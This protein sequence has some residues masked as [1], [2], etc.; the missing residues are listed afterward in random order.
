M[1]HRTERLFLRPAWP[2]DWEEIY[3]GMAD[4]QVVMNLATAPWPYT[5]EDARNFAAR[6][7]DGFLPSFVVTLPEAG[8]IGGAGIGIG[9]D[10]GNVQL[11]YW[12]AREWWG[13]GFATEA[14]RSLLQIAGTLGHKRITASHFIDNP[15][16]GK[17]LRKAGFTPT[18]RIRPAYSLARGRRDP[19]ACFEAKLDGDDDIGPQDMKQAA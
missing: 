19:V 13:K 16:S 9:D 8:L 11:G 4:Q 3:R 5:A 18:G 7:Q 2:E 14:A 15:A 17:V 12:I 6:K 10:T 1:F